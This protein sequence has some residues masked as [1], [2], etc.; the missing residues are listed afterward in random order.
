M[1]IVVTST[2]AN[3]LKKTLASI[4]D[5]DFSSRTLIGKMYEEEDMEDAFEDDQEYGGPGLVQ[6]RGEAAP[7]AVG[8]MDE[9]V[10]TRYWARAF[11]LKMVISEE[12]QDDGKYK[13][14]INLGKRLRRAMGKTIDVQGALTFAR[15]A[16]T[17]YPIGDGLPLSS[18]SHT[19]PHTGTFSNK[20]G[21]PLSPSRMA[22]I[23]VVTSLKT[24]VGHDG[25]VEGYEP[26]AVVCPAAQWAIWDEILH[27]KGA[28]EAGEYNRINVVNRSYGD[29]EV[30]VNPYWTNTTTNWAVLTDNG[31]LKWKWRKR[32]YSRSWVD[33][34]NVVVNFSIGARFARGC[35]DPRA[36]FCVEA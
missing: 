10:Q 4:I 34:D 11:G 9:G 20:M 12:A 21:T 32:P 3:S 2:I 27:S 5:D 17:S 26:K 30:V 33:N 22:F 16:N 25:I 35:S 18:A 6:E 36:V 14:I 13:E 31:G 8:Q 1:S 7:I 28:P 29:T 23:S 24:M 15:M 19:L